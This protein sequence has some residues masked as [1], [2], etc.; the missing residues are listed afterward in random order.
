[1][2]NKKQKEK[3]LKQARGIIKS[4]YKI[5]DCIGD[6]HIARAS[7]KLLKKRLKKNEK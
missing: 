4:Y 3:K 6:K 5:S 2:K 7:N 1:M